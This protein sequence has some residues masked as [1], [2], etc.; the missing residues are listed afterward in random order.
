MYHS[1]SITGLLTHFFFA[2]LVKGKQIVSEV[3]NYFHKLTYRFIESIKSL[4]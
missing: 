2:I 1:I 4:M 3:T